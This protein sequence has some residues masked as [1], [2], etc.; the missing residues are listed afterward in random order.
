MQPTQ[1]NERLMKVVLCWGKQGNSNICR[2]I[3]SPTLPQVTNIVT[4]AA[5]FI[6]IL[7]GITID[8]TA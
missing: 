7:A 4:M 1:S 2:V 8:R 3:P 6:K 5:H